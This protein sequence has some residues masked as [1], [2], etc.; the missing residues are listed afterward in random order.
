MMV[1]VSKVDG[2]WTAELVNG[3]ASLGISFSEE[4]MA[5]SYATDLAETLDC[6]LSMVE[7]TEAV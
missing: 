6:E 1:I 3:P 5:K 2:H 4:W 7:D